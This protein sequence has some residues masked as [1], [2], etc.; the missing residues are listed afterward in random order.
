MRDTGDGITAD[1]L[2]D[3][4]DPFVQAQRGQDGTGLGLA[5]SERLVHLMGGRL[6]VG[7]EVGRGSTFEFELALPEARRAR[8]AADTVGGP[9]PRSTSD[10]IVLVVDHSTATRSLLMRQLAR[11]GVPARA[12]GSASEA[13][14]ALGHGAPYGL[15]LVDIGLPDPGGA[16]DH[17]GDPVASRRARSRLC[18]SWVWWRPAQCATASCAWT[19]ASTGISRSRWTSPNC[20][21]WSTGGCTDRSPGAP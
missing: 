8:S 9:S 11:I 20:A 16:G 6:E 12:V 1:R 3:I 4:F 19:P 7:S 5:I 18:P 2:A 10:R 15:V 17:R 13:I 21:R 14:D